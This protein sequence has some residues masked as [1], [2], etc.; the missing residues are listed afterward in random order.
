MGPAPSASILV[1]G[2]DGA[3]P[4][5]HELAAA[6]PACSRCGALMVERRRRRDGERFPRLLDLPD[7]PVHPAHP[8]GGLN[9]GSRA[10]TVR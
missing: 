9:V 3:E 1:R 8:G 7:L 5:G 4:A 10:E 6:A 2:H